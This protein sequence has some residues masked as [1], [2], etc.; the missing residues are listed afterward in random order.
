MEPMYNNSSVHSVFPSRKI[1]GIAILLLFFCTFIVKL[2]HD[3]VTQEIAEPVKIEISGSNEA[4]IKKIKVF[5][6]SPKFNVYELEKKINDRSFVWRL[7]NRFIRKIWLGLPTDLRDTID[8]VTITIGQ[9]QFPFS[10]AQIGKQWQK[11]RKVDGSVAELLQD[12][13]SI[14]EVPQSVAMSNSA[15]PIFNKIINWPGDVHVFLHTLFFSFLVA[16]LLV[17]AVTSITILFKWTS[18]LNISDGHLPVGILFLL[19]LAFISFYL[20]PMLESQLYKDDLVYSATTKGFYR[21]NGEPS[22]ISSIIDH[23]ESD[24]GSGRFLILSAMIHKT[25]F[26]Y[27][28]NVIVYKA[29]ILSLVLINIIL[30]AIF[31]KMLNIDNIFLLVLLFLLPIYCKEERQSPAILFFQ[32]QVEYILVGNLFLRDSLLSS[33]H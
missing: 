28:N 17:F 20:S 4:Q 9:Q 10:K 19:V 6:I 2:Y 11:K 27:L 32:S 13:W 22:L 14:L 29:Y 24:L 5:R 3:I 26:Y 23:I 12:K 16:L 33:L 15:I 31:L 8:N 30:F 18:K 25:T 21:A 1:T 7:E